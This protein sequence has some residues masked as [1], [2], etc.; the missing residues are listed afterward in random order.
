MRRISSASV[1]QHA[2]RV[3]VNERQDFELGKLDVLVQLVNAGVDRPQL[4]HFRADVD[5][6]ARVRGAAGGGELAVRTRL[7]L[8]GLEDHVGQASPLAEE[9]LRA[10][11]PVE[12]ALDPLFLEDLLDALAKRLVSASG[13]KAEIEIALPLSRDYMARPRA[14]VDVRH[15]EAGRRKAL[16]ALV[17]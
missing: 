12:R 6:E 2:Q 4:D 15:L 3:Q 1:K 11:H 16:V 5:D 8:A 14:G 9:G 7:P 13:R 10:D 17:P